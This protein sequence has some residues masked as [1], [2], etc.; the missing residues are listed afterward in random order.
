M[1]GN[2]KRFLLLF[3]LLGLAT[4]VAGTGFY[5]YL[6]GRELV[7]VVP[8]PVIEEQARAPLIKVGF[9]SRAEVSD[10]K[11][12]HFK[13]KAQMSIVRGDDDNFVMDVESH[14]D[15]SLFLKEAKVARSV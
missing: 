6:F 8:S 4:G 14:Q 5:I 12:R 3:F 9:D 7:Q 15:S 10:W 2:R 13:P 1:S 11:A